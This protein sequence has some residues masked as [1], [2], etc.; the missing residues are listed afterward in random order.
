MFTYSRYAS[1]RVLP[2]L[3]R[4]RTNT[5]CQPSMCSQNYSVANY[6]T[7][8][9]APN[10]DPVG[11][12]T[13]NSSDVH[14]HRDSRGAYQHDSMCTQADSFS[15]DTVC[16]KSLR[17]PVIEG[18]A[19]VPLSEPLC[20]TRSQVKE[21]TGFHCSQSKVG[22]ANTVNPPVDTDPATDAPCVA[23]EAVL[24]GVKG[25]PGVPNKGQLHPGI[26]FGLLPEQ[27]SVYQQSDV[28]EERTE[29]NTN[30]QSQAYTTSTPERGTIQ[31][32][33]SATRDVDAISSTGSLEVDTGPSTQATGTD[34]PVNLSSRVRYTTTDP[35]QSTKSDGPFRFEV[36]HESKK[37]GARVGVIHTPH[38]VITTPNFVGVGTNGTIKGLTSE[39][40]RDTG[41][42]LMF[43]NTYHLLLHPG[44]E[45][46]KA[47]G[48][49]H[50]YA[51]YKGPIITDS[52]GF[53]PR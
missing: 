3:G 13:L 40:T 47:A 39:M 11:D 29:S 34:P 50:R 10:I 42:E 31:G 46:I 5:T 52:G 36:I 6:G 12:S 18:E 19:H 2:T 22:H 43:C 30:V 23:Q 1:A 15:H 32:V 26:N 48:G 41:L 21:I 16:T 38:G 51:N 4:W 17:P 44:P 33:H 27:V 14:Q 20:T 7:T 53:Q 28:L 24:R 49:L 45:I 37:S 35:V 8:Q 9:E 25:D